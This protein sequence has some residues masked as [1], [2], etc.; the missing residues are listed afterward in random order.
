MNSD[1][2]FSGEISSVI[3]YIYLTFKC[4]YINIPLSIGTG[5][6]FLFLLI[7]YLEVYTLSNKSKDIFYSIKITHEFTDCLR[8]IKLQAI[9]EK[10]LKKLF[11][12]DLHNWL[13]LK[14]FY[15]KYRNISVIKMWL[16]IFELIIKL[17]VKK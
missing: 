2:I 16:V 5:F 9:T 14:W 15:I 1:S 7:L 8:S 3:L 4:F 13:W 12:T 10:L 6:F 11:D 17:Y